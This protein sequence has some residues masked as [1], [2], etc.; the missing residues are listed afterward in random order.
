MSL[1]EI[2]SQFNQEHEIFYSV[3]YFDLSMHKNKTVLDYFYKKEVFTIIF[4]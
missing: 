3:I 2:G 4:T 1:Q